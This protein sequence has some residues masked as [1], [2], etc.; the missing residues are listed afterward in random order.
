MTATTVPAAGFGAWRILV[1][2]LVGV[3]A[4]GIGA[5]AGAFLFTDRAAGAGEAAGYVP[6]TAPMYMELRL[7]PGAAQDQA[8]RELLARF[9]EI[10][11]VD[12]TRPLFEQLGGAIDDKI[13]GE[14]PTELRWETD[15]APWF[16]GSVAFAV[17]E[18]PAELLAAA[19]MPVP[20]DPGDPGTFGDDELM[21]GMLVTLGVT[22]PAAARTSIGRLVE[23]GGA[24]DLTET[25]HRG[26]TIVALA[27]EGAY[28]VTD[29]A[30]LVAPD[31]GSIVAALDIAAGGESLADA[32]HV[33]DLA[34]RLPADWLALV[35]FDFTDV[36]AAA[37][38]AQAD[39]PS[40]AAM[41]ALLEGQP[42]RGATVITAEADR[43]VID[44][45][46]GAPTGD[47]ALE[48]ADRGLAG[49]VPADT[50]YFADGGNIGRALAAITTALK[51]AAQ[52]DPE[53]SEQIATA[54]AA[55]GADL[56]ELVEW[57][58]DGAVA[59]GWSVDGPWAGLVLVPTDASVAA[60]RL[61]QL[62]TFAGL[63]SLDPNSGISV[64][65]SDVAGETVTTIRWQGPSTEPSFDAG[66][67]PIEG[68]SLQY[69]VT[70]DRAIIGIGETFVADVLGLAAGDALAD[71]DRYASTIASLG[72][73]ENAG[74]VWVDLAGTVDALVTALEP[75][76]G[77]MDP[78]GQFATG[79]VP[80]L[81]PFDRY[82][83]VSVVD[84][85][86]V[87][88]RAVV[89]VE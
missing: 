20:D 9:P 18:I 74:A 49:E 39:D 13:A 8:L 50:L 89:V 46:A 80:W 1:I 62:A 57:V 40:A 81:R 66:M 73:A 34:G 22:D 5:T 15:V 79:I 17:T 31:A 26:V 60:R 42:M 2:A 63:A 29:D 28:A 35:A 77:V 3:L 12:L 21:P 65:E 45:V 33:T 25:E 85:D 82:A 23:E 41:R 19:S 30:V 70:D 54:E 24:T 68:L 86:V 58:D 47:L 59:A 7:D 61:G 48:N 32:E 88:Q 72:G 14:A 36:M 6:A 75:M 43:L 87:V 76:L 37:M 44:G 84:G 16:D 10:D 83:A 38:D 67:P 4:V 56:E 27:D 11:G 53:A 52:A 71:E 51:G 64:D 78:N 69:T 55:L